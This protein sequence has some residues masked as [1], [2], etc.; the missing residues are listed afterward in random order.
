[1]EKELQE[2]GLEKKEAVIY[3]A[4]L[5]E[6]LSTPTTLAKKT[7]IKRATVY[8]Y[9]ERLQEKGLIGS[10]IRGARKYLSA[11]PPRRALKIYLHHKKD[12][13]AQEEEMLIDVISQLE[14]VSRH[15]VP[16]SK[17]YFYQDVSG[18]RFVLNKILAVKQ[19]V[20]WI[21]SIETLLS[22]ISERQLH[23]IF[24]TKRLQQGTVSYAITDRKILR[25]DKFSE[26]IGN[27]RIFRFLEEDLSVP[28]ILCIFGNNICLLSQQKGKINIILIEDELMSK[29]ALF[30]FQSLWKNLSKI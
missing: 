14:R 12:R 26:L 6:N 21:G 19:N 24:T 1:M 15:D 3:L 30:L 11:I 28:A 16:N 7:G 27:K 5:E 20:R 23:R 4:C 25:Y 10:E 22:V 9:L 8:F 2:L 29:M 13:I 18:A 17:V